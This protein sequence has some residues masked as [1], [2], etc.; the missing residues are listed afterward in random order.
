MCAPQVGALA[1]VPAERVAAMQRVIAARAHA[2]QYATAD[3]AALRASGAV[4]ADDAAYEDAFDVL[5]RKAW[6]RRR[7]L[8]PL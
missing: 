2:M 3:T 6:E 8:A 5:V 4:P 7:V 1:A